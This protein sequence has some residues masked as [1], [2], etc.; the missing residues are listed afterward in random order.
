MLYSMNNELV[1]FLEKE[2]C[3][4]IR[5]VPGRGFCAIQRFAFTTGLSYGL[6]FEG[7]EG[8]YCYENRMDAIYALRDW[9]GVGDPPDN[10][11][12]KHKGYA[13]EYNNPHR[14][15]QISEP[16]DKLTHLECDGLTRV[17]S[18]ALHKQGVIHRVYSGFVIF[19]GKRLF[20]YWIIDE[21][22]WYID[23]RLRMWFGNN[24]KIP[25]GVFR[26]PKTVTYDKEVELTPTTDEV[27]VKILIGDE[28][29]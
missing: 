1:T 8:R 11:W 23:Y 28:R 6:D 10:N 18:F 21:Y 7:R 2:N 5:E 17:I 27:I 22:G 19:E 13:G 4:H 9:D 20:H 24:H 25:H 12:V 26:N 14:I 16:Y 3:T 29:I 15:K